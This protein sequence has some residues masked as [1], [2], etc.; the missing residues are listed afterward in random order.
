[1]SSINMKPSLK[2]LGTHN[3][4]N[5]LRAL[6]DKVH[7]SSNLWHFE[8]LVDPTCSFYVQHKEL[9]E[10]WNPVPAPILHQQEELNV[11]LN[12]LKALNFIEGLFDQPTACTIGLSAHSHANSLPGAFYTWGQ[13]AKANSHPDALS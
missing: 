11:A 4:Q 12:I 9:I 5:K 3:L 2:A 6:V 7:T 13:P 1:M 10:L 8:D